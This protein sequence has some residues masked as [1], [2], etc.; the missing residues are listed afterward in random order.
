M[1]ITLSPQL[2]HSHSLYLGL[3]GHHIK[4]SKSQIIM[5]SGKFLLS[6]FWDSMNEIALGI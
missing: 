5:V 3:S 4:V 2:K 6:D 1:S